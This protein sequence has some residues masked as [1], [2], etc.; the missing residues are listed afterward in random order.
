MRI[1]LCLSE[2]YL[3]WKKGRVHLHIQN[4][5]RKDL[6]KGDLDTKQKRNYLWSSGDYEMRCYT[7]LVIC[8][9]WGVGKWGRIS[10]VFSSPALPLGE[11]DYQNSGT[12]N[13]PCQLWILVDCMPGASKKKEQLWRYSVCLHAQTSCQASTLRRCSG[14]RTRWWRPSRR[15]VKWGSRSRGNSCNTTSRAWRQS[16]LP[17]P[18]SAS[19]TAGLTR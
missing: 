10:N 12:G 4:Q 2:W 15:L 19:T 16:C 6:L 17:S 18:Q 8:D 14:T 1:C 7:L 13:R 11:R 9:W 3:K 5:K